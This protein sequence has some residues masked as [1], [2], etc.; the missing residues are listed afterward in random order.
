MI[1]AELILTWSL[2]VTALGFVARLLRGPGEERFARG[3]FR[4]DKDQFLL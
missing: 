1:F 3:I 4:A 2:V